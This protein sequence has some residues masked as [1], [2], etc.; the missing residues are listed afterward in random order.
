MAFHSLL[1]EI[2]RDHEDGRVTQ[3]AFLDVEDAK[4]GSSGQRRELK[5]H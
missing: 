1:T 3:E 4:E 2:R 5:V